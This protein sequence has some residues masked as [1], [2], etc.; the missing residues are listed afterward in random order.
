MGQSVM[1]SLWH[2]TSKSSSCWFS[3]K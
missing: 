2:S 1:S 3:E